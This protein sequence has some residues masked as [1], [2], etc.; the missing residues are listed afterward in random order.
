MLVLTSRITTKG[1]MKEY[2]TNKLIGGKT[3]KKIRLTPK[4]SKIGGIKR[5]AKQMTQRK[6]KVDGGYKLGYYQQKCK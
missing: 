4:K 2:I 6:V 5:N 1:I 3:G